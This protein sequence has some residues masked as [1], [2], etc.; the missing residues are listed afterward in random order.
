MEDS[1]ILKIHNAIHSTVTGIM[2]DD[3][4]YNITK[5]GNGCRHIV[6]K[7]NDE[8]INFMEQNKKKGSSWAKLALE[9]NK[10]TW[11]MRAK[12]WIRIV[13]GQIQAK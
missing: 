7:D 5:A 2:I 8:E 12:N 4:M 1:T 9:G 10:I 13:N 3:V 6:Y 11:G